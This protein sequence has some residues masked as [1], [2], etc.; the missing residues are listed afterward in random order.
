MDRHLF[1]HYRQWLEEINQNGIYAMVA[2]SSQ[3]YL[4]AVWYNFAQDRPTITEDIVSGKMA[5][6][7]W[8]SVSN[9][10]KGWLVEDDQAGESTSE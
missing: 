8:D 6:R 5:G 7:V 9:S 1:E 4:D 3:P 2:Q 10:V